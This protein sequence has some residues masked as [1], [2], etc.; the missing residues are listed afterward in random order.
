MYVGSE[1]SG[2]PS[3]SLPIVSLLAHFGIPTTSPI[4]QI[5]RRDELL[6]HCYATCEFDS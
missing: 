3:G 2:F 4:S 5:D 6:A 1:F